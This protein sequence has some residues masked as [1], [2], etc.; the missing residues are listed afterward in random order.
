VQTFT[1]TEAGY[2]LQ[3]PTT[4]VQAPLPDQG[5]GAIHGMAYS[6]SEGAVEVYW[7]EAFG[8]ACTTGTEQVNLATGEVTAC[9]ATKSDGTEEWSQIAYQ[10]SG[11][12]YSL[13]AYTSNDQQSS[14][15]LILQ[16]LSTVNFIPSDT[17]LQSASGRALLTRM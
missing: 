8:G 14:H 4:W 12:D 10:N 9:H 16:V 7:G 3:A 1:N 2:T 11:I 13:R 6:G 15:D 17:A 5:G